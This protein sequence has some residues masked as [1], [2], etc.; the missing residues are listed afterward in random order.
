MAIGIE[1]TN[2][3]TCLLVG[4]DILVFSGRRNNSR[5]N[6]DDDDDVVMV[7]NTDWWGRLPVQ[8]CSCVLVVV[9]VVVRAGPAS[10]LGRFCNLSKVHK[11]M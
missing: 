10:R 8:G 3:A 11:M 9:V 4:N 6:N 7:A 5:V 1:A 2:D